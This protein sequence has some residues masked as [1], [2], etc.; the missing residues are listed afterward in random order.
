MSFVLVFLNSCDTN[1]VYEKN[2]EIEKGI[3]DN[4][5]KAVFEVNITDTLAVQNIYINVRNTELY[6]YRNLYFF[7]K[8]SSPDGYCLVDTFECF[9]ADLNGKWLG[10]GMGDIWDNKILYKRN[11]LFPKPGIYT[12]ELE[13]AMRHRYLP[14]IMEVGL[15]IEKVGS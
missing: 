4:Q 1:K 12:F 14:F 2:I 7:I 6:Q 9:L 10:D 11:I 13:Q 3:W 15:R 5:K 8:T